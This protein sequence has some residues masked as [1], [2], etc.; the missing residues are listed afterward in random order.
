MPEARNPSTPR[1]RRRA[2]TRVVLGDAAVVVGLWGLAVAQPL[3]DLYG[4]NGELFV[5]AGTPGGGIVA[6]AVTITL[7]PPLLMAALQTAA[8]LVHRSAGRAVHTALTALLGGLLAAT[9]V[10]RAGIDGTGVVLIPAA[11]AGV[12]LAWGE[13]RSRPLASGLRYLALG[14]LLFLG[15]LVFASPSSRLIW[16]GGNGAAAAAS[17]DAPAP[18]VVVQL[19]ELPLA[20]LLS[21][22]LTVN[23]ARFP[24]FAALADES[25]W[26]PDATSVASET[27]L[28]VPSLVTGLVPDPDSLPA[29]SDHPRSLFTLLGDRYD[30]DVHEEVTTLCPASRCGATD[31]RTGSFSTLLTDAAVV[32]GHVA[33]PASLRARLPRVDQSWSGFV[34]GARVTEPST[35]ATVSTTTATATATAT[36]QADWADGE[37]FARG[38]AGQG[39]DLQAVI[40]G[41][42]ASTADGDPR[43]RLTYVHAL[44]PHGPWL[45]TPTDQQHSDPGPLLGLTTESTWSVE[46][47]GVRQGLQRH[48]LQLGYADL[49]LGRLVQGLKDIG[50]WD[51]ALVV[52]AADHGVAFTPGRPLREPTDETMREIYAVPLFVKYPHQT[53]GEIDPRNARLIDVLPTIVDVLGIETDWVFDG[54]SLRG[55]P[56]ANDDKP[57]VD[58]DAPMPADRRAGLVEVVERN[59]GLLPYGDDWLSVA[60]IEPYGDLVGVPVDQLVLGDPSPMSFFSYHPATAYDPASTRSPVLRSGVL[61]LAGTEPP[62]TGLITMNGVV[63]GVAVGFDPEGDDATYTGLISADFFT[64]GYNDLGLLVPDEPGGRVFHRVALVDQ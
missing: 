44:L 28:S 1:V 27:S 57:V 52:V 14:P 53:T 61:H 43:P 26:Y 55:A 59:H 25:T 63:A 2:T 37:A 54:R 12:A 64:Y 33:L 29:A 24:N 23:R 47:V 3:L 21:R 22:D 4:R 31:D 20:S 5:A 36:S 11:A 34:D 7:V 40:D 60:R 42:A 32:Y 46:P 51:D 62:T 39:Q 56:P 50:V 15:A 58:L 17:I 30:L 16:D 19:D 41:L 35:T 10:R 13:R 18:I 48:L 45:M 6:F 49:Y 8:G 38:P 9:L